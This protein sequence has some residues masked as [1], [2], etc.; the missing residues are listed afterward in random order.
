MSC[1]AKECNIDDRCSSCHDCDDEMWLQV[2]SY[3][4]K[5]ALQQEKKAKAA[6]SSSFSGFSPSLPGPLCELSSSMESVIVTSLPIS[7]SCSVTFSSSSPI[8]L[9]LLFISP[10]VTFAGEPSQKRREDLGAILISK[11]KMWV[12]FQKCWSEVSSSLSQP[13]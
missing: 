10:D 6:S 4:S 5:L 7:S 13:L 1:R 11:E 3:R 2:S 9:A 12:Q 8:V